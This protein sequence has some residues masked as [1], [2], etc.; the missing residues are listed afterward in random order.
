ML[1][2][3]VFNRREWPDY[4]GEPVYQQKSKRDRYG[5][6]HYLHRGTTRKKAMARSE[7]DLELLEEI[8]DASRGILCSC[9]ARTASR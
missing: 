2:E 5:G 9:T 3:G 6:R 1:L 7:G 4:A 8:R